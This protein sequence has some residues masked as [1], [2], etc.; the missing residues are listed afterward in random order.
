MSKCRVGRGQRK[1][2][3]CQKVVSLR[4]GGK[5]S[6]QRVV[7]TPRRRWSKVMPHVPSFL[8]AAF[9]SA[10]FQPLA[11]EAHVIAG[12]SFHHSL[13]VI[14]I[15]VG[16]RNQISH[17]VPGP[18]TPSLPSPFPSSLSQL[19]HDSNPATNWRAFIPSPL[20]CDTGGQPFDP[21]SCLQPRPWFL[22][23]A[24]LLRGSGVLV[25][26][27]RH[28]R[29]VMVLVK[30]VLRRVSGSCF[31]RGNSSR[32]EAETTKQAQGY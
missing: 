31:G 26:L 24:M 3:T 25:Q 16:A 2:V 1:K 4:N 19:P 28:V 22:Q 8:L 21:T 10:G 13:C 14:L 9:F 17:V 15:Q 30:T 11:R 7:A 12:A 5:K 27:F 18:L 6:Y 23:T 20:P 29:V 32:G